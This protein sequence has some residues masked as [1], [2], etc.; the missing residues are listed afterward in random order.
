MKCVYLALLIVILAYFA[1]VG[2]AC[3][4]CKQVPLE[5]FIDDSQHSDCSYKSGF[6][7]QGPPSREQDVRDHYWVKYAHEYGVKQNPAAPFVGAIVNYTSNALVCIS[8]NQRALSNP[9]WS[10]R[11]NVHGEIVAMENCTNQ[12]LPDIIVNG[13]KQANPG[14]EDMI[15][16]GNIETC[17]MCAQSMLYRGLRRAVFGARAS[18]LMS[19][20]CWDQSALTVQEVVDHASRYYTFKYLRGPLPEYEDFILQ[21]FPSKCKKN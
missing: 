13:S 1:N 14:W 5:K 6:A 8:V 9:L 2:D 3:A 18:E 21:G 10:Y 7:R 11:F 17:P 15:L 12:F 4:D 19:K 20:R 16:Y